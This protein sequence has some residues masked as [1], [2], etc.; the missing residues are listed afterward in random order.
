MD[1]GLN[2]QGGVTTRLV[3]PTPSATRPSGDS[4]APKTWRNR[5]AAEAL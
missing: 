5:P 4:P 2:D 1:L 3:F